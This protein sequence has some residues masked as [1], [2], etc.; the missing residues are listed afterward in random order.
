MTLPIMQKYEIY[1]DSGVRW[2][3][4]IPEHWSTHRFR[5]IFSFGKGLTITK[6]D[7]HE[8][9]IPCVN[10]GEVHSK[11]GFELDLSKHTLK[12]VNEEYFKTNPKSLLSVGDF[13]FADTSED[14]EGSGNF[15]QLV[16][17]GIIFAGYHTVVAKPVIGNNNRYV[18]Y[19]LD[20]IS[21]RN[22]IRNIVKG[23]K[24]FSITKTILNNTNVWLPPISEQ[25]TIANYL[26]E[27]T[28][29]INE[30][31]AIK[32][33]QIALLKDRKQIITQKAVTQGINPNVPMKE[34]GVDWIGQIPEHWE[35]IQ[36]KYLFKEINDRTETGK[37][38][39]LSLRMELGLVPHDDVSD[40]PISD[41][42]LIGYKRTSPGQIVMNRMRAAIGIF[43]IPRTS[44]L[45]SPD[46]SVFDSIRDL[47]LEY[48]LLL[49][50]TTLLGTQFRLNSKGLGTGSSGFMRLYSENFGA[51]KVPFCSMDEQV[52]IFDFIES[53]TN[54][55]DNSINFIILQI[56]KLKEY[57]TT[58][59]NS[60]VTGK[61]KVV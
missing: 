30:A 24:V 58:L 17:E 48:F 2:L 50:K 34:S 41:A 32:E 22:Q 12:C 14:I 35:A 9:G 1:K 27:K 52:K 42:E 44:G 20:S 31:I 28:S 13:I 51:I 40:K 61:I 60:A 33:K 8:T 15:T 38:T 5:Y 45:V 36:L 54:K 53:E 6:E 3:G 29:Q 7:L 4:E 21:Y 26:D 49:F 59:I 43:G 57:K 25:T 39:L 19:V 23:V 16:S 11:F 18:A 10:Y 55:M 37:E 47:H 46:Y 56:E